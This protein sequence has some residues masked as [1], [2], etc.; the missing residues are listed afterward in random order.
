V[1]GAC[2]RDCR[3]LELCKDGIVGWSRG[4]ECVGGRGSLFCQLAHKQVWS[5]WQR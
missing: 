5:Q 2:V 3:L 4:G 1:Y